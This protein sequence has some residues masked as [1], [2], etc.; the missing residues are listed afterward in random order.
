MGAAST[1]S[2]MINLQLQSGTITNIKKWFIQLQDD[3]RIDFIFFRFN[4][5]RLL[6]WISVC[7]KLKPIQLLYF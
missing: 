7:Y 1:Y 2:I 4:G 6:R 5:A 3:L